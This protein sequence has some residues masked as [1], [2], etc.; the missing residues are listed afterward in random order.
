LRLRDYLIAQLGEIVV[1]D[2]EAFPYRSSSRI[3][4]F[5]RRCGFDFVHHGETRRI[6]AKE[7]LQ[8]LNLAGS[9]ATDLPSDAIRR[10][11]TELFDVDD[12]DRCEK[13]REDA[14]EVLNKVLSKQGLQVY[15]DHARR[16]HV[17]NDG[18]GVS[19]SA[20]EQEPRPLSAQELWQHK[21][22]ETFL[23]SA[24]EDEFTE[25][26]LV[27]LFQ[28]LGFHRV[29][30]SG[31]VEETLEYGKDLWMKYQ[32]PTGLSGI[33]ATIEIPGPRTDCGGHRVV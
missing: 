15:F 8:E 26:L 14:L 29:S 1:G 12:F 5:F 32:L 28:R 7:R 27:P 22:V 21:A 11:I 24:S 9:S 33:Q 3:T 4:E 6:W 16:S 25:R 2:N 19:S 20:S 13:S 10:V 23:E 17:R 31:H 18:T 30:A